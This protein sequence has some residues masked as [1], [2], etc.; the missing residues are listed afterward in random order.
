M[1]KILTYLYKFAM[2]AIRKIILFM[3]LLC[4]VTTAKADDQDL[5]LIG[6]E[7]G[8]YTP[9]NITNLRSL[10]FTQSQEENTDVSNSQGNKPIADSETKETL[11]VTN[12]SDHTEAAEK[13]KTPDIS[14]DTDTP[15]VPK[16]AETTEKTEAADISNATDVP[17]VPT[18][19]ETTE[20]TETPDISKDTDTPEVPKEAAATEDA[21]TSEQ[22][23]EHNDENV[24]HNDE[25]ETNDQENSSPVDMTENKE[26][27]NKEQAAADNG[28]HSLEE[29]D[30]KSIMT[31]LSESVTNK[32]TGYSEYTDY[33]L[34][35]TDSSEEQYVTFNIEA[36]NDY[37]SISFTAKVDSSSDIG[38]TEIVI[39]VNK[40]DGEGSA[41]KYHFDSST[42]IS[43]IKIDIDGASTV[44]IG[45]IDHSGL[46]SRI[47]FANPTVSQK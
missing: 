2:K 6:L 25:T 41:S 19:S 34:I 42:E 3:S 1:H 46:A 16:E 22:H 33:F 8:A 15:E 37:K 40:S 23:E 35:E 39:N 29:P 32:T 36:L 12:T 31:I 10:S 27:N 28:K 47:V 11:P 38:D 20:K 7:D 26:E 45:V 13:N 9:L 4:A 14:K 30:S 24:G 17:E 44:S 43:P 5:Y 18:E 21:N